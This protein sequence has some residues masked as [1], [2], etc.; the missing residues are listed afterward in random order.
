[1]NDN[2]GSTHFNCL[3]I[4]HTLTSTPKCDLMFWKYRKTEQFACEGHRMYY[5]GPNLGGFLFGGAVVVGLGGRSH[6]FRGCAVTPALCLMRSSAP[7]RQ[8]PQT[9]CCGIFV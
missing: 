2:Y 7:L 5:V 6:R 4:Q 3:S 9:I 1:M 8:T